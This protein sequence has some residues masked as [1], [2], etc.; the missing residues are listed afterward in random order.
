MTGIFVMDKAS[1][2]ALT[3]I[4]LVLDVVGIRAL[5]EQPRYTRGGDRSAMTV[6]LSRARQAR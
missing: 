3:L 6:P 5:Y 1:Y 2:F 4:E